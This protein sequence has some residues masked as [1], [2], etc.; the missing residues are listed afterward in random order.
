MTPQ[1][2]DAVP[3]RDSPWKASILFDRIRA[4]EGNLDSGHAMS[5][6]EGDNF[7]HD[8]ELYSVRRVSL[9]GMLL[10]LLKIRSSGALVS[11]FSLLVFAGVKMQ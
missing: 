6:D 8:V 4:A 11:W 10:R 9:R 3:A 7:G 2:L 5:E 1:C